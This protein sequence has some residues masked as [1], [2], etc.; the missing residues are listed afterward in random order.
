MRLNDLLGHILDR[1]DLV[2]AEAHV[3]TADEV[4]GW[5]R[6]A[7]DFFINQGLLSP[8]APANSLECE[9]C[10]ERCFMRVVIAPADVPKN[11]GPFIVCNQRDDIGRVAIAADRLKRWRV[12][13]G[14]LAGV[15]S[16]L[17]EIDQTPRELIRHRLWDL[18][19]V[20]VGS[21]LSEAFL[22]RGLDWTDGEDTLG[23]N[24]E[25]KESTAP[26]IF[27]PGKTSNGFLPHA[28]V[29]A[30]SRM[31]RIQKDR[32]VLDREGIARAIAAKPQPDTIIGNV[33]RNE[34]QYWTISFE[35]HTFRLRHS[36][37]LQYLGFLLANAGQEL[38]A[39]EILSGVESKAMM[40]G[41]NVA[42]KMREQHLVEDGLKVS[43]LGDAGPLLDR[44]AVSEYR[45]ELQELGE[46]LEEARDFN[47]LG[48]AEALE[49]QIEAIRKELTSA[50][51]PKGR[52]RKGVDPNERARKTLSKAVGRALVQIQKYDLD[53]WRHLQK[54]LDLGLTSSYNPHPLMNWNT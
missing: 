10:E 5:P 3:F 37:G 14:Q 15:L 12:D 45:R 11:M 46:E 33:F 35:G 23:N 50:V 7:L 47:D 31:L 41:H 30:L 6:E 48:R 22:A 24:R 21:G 8:T 4:A 51:G 20:N 29:F 25:L 27:A 39:H 28:S 54:A 32:L 40:P 52:I 38:H 19:K 44:Q 17:L 36:K 26:L 34:G 53:L 1:V 2:T 42:S 9:G 43:S 49:N 13:L 18:G 16:T